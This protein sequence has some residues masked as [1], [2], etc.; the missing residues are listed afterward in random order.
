MVNWLPVS[1]IHVFI[2]VAILLKH[3]HIMSTISV[4]RA[5]TVEKNRGWAMF[6]LFIS[7]SLFFYLVANHFIIHH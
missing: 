4:N 5:L 7:V 6:I 3:L 2:N 1:F